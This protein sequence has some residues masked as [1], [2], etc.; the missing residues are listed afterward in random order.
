MPTTARSICTDAIKES[1]ALG[2]GQTALPEDINDAFTRLQRMVN[3]W[4]T[5]RWLVPSLQDIKFNSTGAKSYS[6]GLGGDINIQRPND[7]KGAYVV[8]LNTGSNPV[9]LQMKKIFSYEDYI[10]IA[11]KNLPSLPDHFFYDA[12]YP[13]ANYFAWP[14]PQAGMYELHIIIQSL[15]GFG[16]TI[17][18]GA[19]TNG[20]ALYTD[21]IYPNVALTGGIGS[22]ATADITV[23]AGKVALLNLDTGGQ[24]YAIG[25]VL[26]CA[27]A[28]IGG[29]GAGFTYTVDSITSTPDSQIIAPI[30]YEEAIMYNLALRACSFYQVDPIKTTKEIAKSSLNV[31]RKAN[32]QIPT[33]SMPAAPGVRTGRS[34]N[35]YNADGY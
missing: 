18:T 1:G 17:A 31:I 5:N 24:D 9:S 21:A 2:V 32:T 20:G 3:V 15:I 11:V 30:E 4:Q 34:F 7:I 22:G 19:I 23:T 33:L 35:L 8:Q 29:T 14:I 25:N 6:I 26:S 12:Q 16:S 27:A 28:D 13:L 10:R